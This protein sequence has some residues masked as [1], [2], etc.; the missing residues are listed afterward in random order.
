MI[1]LL[2]GCRHFVQHFCKKHRVFSYAP[3]TEMR[4]ICSRPL[5]DKR[6]EIFDS[7][8]VSLDYT[9]KTIQDRILSKSWYMLHLAGGNSHIFWNVHPE[10]WGRWTQFDWIIFFWSGLKLNHLPVHACKFE[11]P[12]CPPWRVFWKGRF[13]TSGTPR[14]WSQCIAHRIDRV[15][16]I[17]MGVFQ[18]VG[19]SQNGWWKEWNTLL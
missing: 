10:N 19:V 13:E 12:V 16:Y 8:P 7:F 2:S 17:Y 15:W 11:C 5:Q 3:T 1:R 9:L 4:G 6:F 18:I 14:H